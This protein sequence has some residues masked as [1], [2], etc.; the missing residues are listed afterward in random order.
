[1]SEEAR[2]FKEDLMAIAVELEAL[3]KSD[4]IVESEALPVLRQAVS[5]LEALAASETSKSRAARIQRNVEP[6]RAVLH[7]LKHRLDY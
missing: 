4:V 3:R 5:D 2:K 6:L 1:M 7:I